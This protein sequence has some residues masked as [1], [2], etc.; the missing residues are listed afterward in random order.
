MKM[1]SPV[2]TVASFAIAVV[3]ASP[4][5]LDYSRLD[6]DMT[7]SHAPAPTRAKHLTVTQARSTRKSL[8]RE[9]Q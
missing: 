6:P 3:S 1:S 7:M 8:P 4:I 9:A 2:D 5:C